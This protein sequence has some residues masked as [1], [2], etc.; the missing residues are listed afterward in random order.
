MLGSILGG[1]AGSVVSGLFG[2]DRADDSEGF[3]RER[4]DQEYARQKEFAQMGIRWKAEDAKAAGLH[5]LA[6]I[7]GV[8]ASYSPT[9]AMP[10]RGSVPDFSGTGE[11]IGDY[12]EKM[13]QNTS[14]AQVA[15]QTVTER[16]LEELAIRNAELRN[17]SLELD[18]A[19]KTA[20]LLGQ[21]R[22]PPMP[23]ALGAPAGAVTVEPSK[24]VAHAPGRPHVEAART[25]MW[26][27]FRTSPNVTLRAPSQAAAESFEILGPF[28]GPAAAAV[29][30]ADETWNGPGAPKNIRLPKGYEWRWNRMSQRYEAYNPRSRPGRSAGAGNI[31][32]HFYP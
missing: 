2:K 10:D 13:G 14:R 1:I 32:D 28:A 8:G 4:S 9:I 6:A 18:L 3:A 11:R 26:K 23:S 20:S 22:N 5:P 15:T 17:S 31:S 19:A 29:A 7:G 24:E 25:P 27:D 30:W 21:P 12:L 16:R